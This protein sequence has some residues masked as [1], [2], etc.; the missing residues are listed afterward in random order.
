MYLIE[1]LRRHRRPWRWKSDPV[2]MYEIVSQ[3]PVVMYEIVSQKLMQSGS[4]GDRR[5]DQGS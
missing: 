3:K 2:V 1:S 4:D 5:R